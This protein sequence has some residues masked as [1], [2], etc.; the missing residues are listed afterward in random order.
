MDLTTAIR[1]IKPQIGTTRDS[2]AVLCDLGAFNNEERST[3]NII[4]AMCEGGF[5]RQMALLSSS[6]NQWKATA[7]DII[8]KMANQ[9]GY[10]L[11]KV[12]AN[13]QKL[14]IGLGLVNTSFDWESEFGPT[15]VSKTN[16]TPVQ[17]TATGQNNTKPTTRTNGNTP[18]SRQRRPS[19]E[20]VMTFHNNASGMSF[21]M[22]KVDGGTFYMGLTP[23]MAAKLMREGVDWKTRY[24]LVTVDS[25]YIG[26]TVVTQALWKA[27]MNK[28]TVTQPGWK[29]MMGE[30]NNPSRFK[31]DDLP[32]E[33]VSWR[34]CQEFISKLREATGLEFRLPTEAEWEFAA[35]GGNLSKG[36]TYA[37]S[38]DT[39][40]I[41]WVDENQYYGSNL[42][43]TKP[44]K[45]KLPNELG[46]YDMNGN[47][48]E[49]CQ[50]WY[51]DLPIGVLN[52]PKGPETGQTKVLRGFSAMTRIESIKEIPCWRNN[53]PPHKRNPK[54]SDEG[55]RWDGFSYDAY[56]FRLA[57]SLNGY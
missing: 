41:A 32:V 54:L 10:Q 44:V 27:V 45:T 53:E 34:N 48:W 21:K 13:L 35:R 49:W 50:D 11:E 33:N 25:Y 18:K 1:K 8:Y 17:P 4:K 51:G 7:H 24:P 57:L 2:Y 26:E 6:N 39:K 55:Y 14:A 23:K 29:P 40:D 30:L 52:N 43:S 3:R 12:S 56:G 28:T 36:F 19:G 15:T 46:L 16:I 31:G 9:Y 20:P 38:N 5:L 42:A 22:V 37:G 47:V